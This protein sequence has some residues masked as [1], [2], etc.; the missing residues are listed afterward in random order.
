MNTAIAVVGGGITG[1]SAA[2]ELRRAG[3]EFVLLEA[4]DRLGGKIKGA[5][6]GGVTVDAGPDGFLVRDRDVINLC[7]ELGLE[8]QIVSPVESRAFVCA[9]GVLKPLPEK[10][11]LGAPYD[12]ESAAH[13][14]VLSAAGLAELR[15][16]LKRDAPALDGDSSLGAVLRP[17]IGDETFERLVD[18]LLGAVNAGSADVMSAEAC[19][20]SLYD[21]ARPGGPF[22]EALRNAVRQ[23]PSERTPGYGP[24][25]VFGGLRGGITRIVDA[26]AEKLG[27]AVRLRFPVLALDRARPGQS[28]RWTL[29]TPQGSVT[30]DAVILTT[31]AWVTARLLE[32]HSSQ[33]AAILSDI[34][35]ADVA[36]VALV[37]DSSHIARPLNGSGFVV[38]RGQGLLTTACSWASAKWEHLRAPG[39]A[40]L[41]VSAGRVDDH[42][43]LDLDDRQLVLALVDE[44]SELGVVG[45]AAAQA[46]VTRWP[47]SL[48]QYRPGHLQR[49]ASAES[50][51]S[52][53]THGLF[54]AGAAL[55]GLGL[56]ACV[57]QGRSAA[58]KALAAVTESR[59]GV[60][61]R[62]GAVRVNGG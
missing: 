7:C 59:S 15:S 19:A 14:G 4:R 46:H 58:A 61:G 20:P 18:P 32:T 5:A 62:D 16:S 24:P 60:H 56:P 17:R 9:D 47:R 55:R 6:V 41:R 21:A 34:S 40:L 37:F 29:Q 12:V 51:L 10:S 43:W 42:T 52:T 8:R 27:N 35:Y 57:R 33:A 11:L 36:I 39:R 25:A 38:P 30:A 13:S 26:L 3:A 50:C 2:H 54:T 22:G 48:P 45:G 23:R 28:T 53:D 1:L 44:L 49:I 31:P